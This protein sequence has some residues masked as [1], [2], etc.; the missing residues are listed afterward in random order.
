MVPVQTVAA[1]LVVASL[2]GA[3]WDVT[4]QRIPNAF[5]FS[6]IGAAIVGQTL[7][8]G[9]A[10][11]VAALAIAIAAIVV[12][13]FLHRCGWLGGGDVKLL[14]GIAAGLG[15]ADV[16][17]LLIYTGLAGGALAILT[18]LSQRELRRTLVQVV[19]GFAYP[20]TSLR[21][22]R[23]RQ[24]IPYALAIAAGSMLVLLSHTALPV[25]RLPI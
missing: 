5:T 1:V 11:G 2:A 14:A 12:G 9:P 19:R 20:G 22:A 15:A 10:A 25:L 6:I 8:F 18:T 16:P 3:A 21:D 24:P 13:S 23:R 4:T 17:A 7:A